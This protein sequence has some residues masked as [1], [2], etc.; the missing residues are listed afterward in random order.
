MKVLLV[1]DSTTIRMMLKGLLKQLQI[2]DI[3]EAANGLEALATLDQHT[4]DAV[5]LDIHMPHMDGLAFLAELRRRPALADLPVIVISSDTGPEQAARAAELGAKA[6]VYKPFRIEALR[7]A[8]A[9]AQ[10]GSACAAGTG[11][12]TT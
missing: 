12:Q 8:L 2:T 6:S 10:A 4:V 5:L 3:V 1:D 11:G 7:Q 9:T